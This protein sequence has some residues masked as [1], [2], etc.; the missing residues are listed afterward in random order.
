M[1]V[2]H[3]RAVAFVFAGGEEKYPAE[4]GRVTCGFGI[5]SVQQLAHLTK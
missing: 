3:R 5:P 1:L 2:M 4:R